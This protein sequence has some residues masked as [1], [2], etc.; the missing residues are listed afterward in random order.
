MSVGFGNLLPEYDDTNR[1]CVVSCHISGRGGRNCKNKY[2]NY[3]L[4]YNWAN[5]RGKRHKQDISR[6][7]SVR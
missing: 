6:L 3:N 5:K 2:N 7:M 1:A 4:S